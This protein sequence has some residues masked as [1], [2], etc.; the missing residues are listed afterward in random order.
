MIITQSQRSRIAS[1]AIV[2]FALSG[3]AAT[4]IETATDT[5]LAAAKV[6]FKAGGAIIDVIDSDEDD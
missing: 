2:I 3:C 1:F 6:P 4:I 5:A